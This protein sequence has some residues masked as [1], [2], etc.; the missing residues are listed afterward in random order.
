MSGFKKHL[1]IGFITIAILFIIIHSTTTWLP[2]SLQTLIMTVIIT[3]I[4]SLLPDIDH[5]ISTITW[6]FLGVGILGLLF[7]V[8]NMLYNF[9]RD[10]PNLTIII[11]SAVFLL[12][13][14]LCAIFARH[15][16]IIHTVR[17]G[18]IFA[19]TPYILTHSLILCILAFA[20]YYSHLC[21]DGLWNRL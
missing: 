16:G 18:A 10:V 19:I 7:G 17:A 5:R 21:A 9:F 13:V 8:T 1:L 2:L 3:Y 12:L 4:F 14:F 20:A 15:R 6:T 11:S